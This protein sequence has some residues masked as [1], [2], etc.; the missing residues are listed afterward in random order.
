MEYGEIEAPSL[1]PNKMD[2]FEEEDISCGPSTFSN[3]PK[4]NDEKPMIGPRGAGGN[5][6]IRYPSHIDGYLPD[7]KELSKMK[8]M[9]L[10][11]GFMYD[12]YG[13]KQKIAPEQTRGFKETFYCQTCK[14][15]LNSKDTMV[16]HMMG[17][18]HMKV[19]FRL[20]ILFLSNFSSSNLRGSLQ[21]RKGS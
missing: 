19:R 6:K 16:S 1:H 17:S 13:H 7:H 18:K 8:M 12:G 9:G 21:R 3:L 2:K 4:L 15:E 14:I 10:S 5:L 20:E 11:T